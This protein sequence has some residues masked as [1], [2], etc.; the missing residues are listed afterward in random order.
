MQ[1]V[2]TTLN[3]SGG[4]VYKFSWNGLTVRLNKDLYG[5]SFKVASN[6]VKYRLEIIRDL[7]DTFKEKLDKEPEFDV[8]IRVGNW[9]FYN[10]MDD[11][12]ISNIDDGNVSNFLN[13]LIGP[14][15][16]DF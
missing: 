16:I 2:K 7:I 11:I 1:E 10:R 14:H 6:S 15:K 12:R 13:I 5:L 4:F 8:G 3:D 9:S